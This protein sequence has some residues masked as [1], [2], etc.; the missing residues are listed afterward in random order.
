MDDSG[1]IEAWS[2]GDFFSANE[3]NYLIIPFLLLFLLLE[4]WNISGHFQFSIFAP[5]SHVWLHNMVVV[6][7]SGKNFYRDGNKSGEKV[8]Q[9]EFLL[10][11]SSMGNFDE[12]S[13]YGG[14]NFAKPITKDSFSVWQGCG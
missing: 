6:Q 9:D 7:V 3:K 2:P 11:F 10:S 1:V 4:N 8:S 13:E 5:E 12:H 14:E